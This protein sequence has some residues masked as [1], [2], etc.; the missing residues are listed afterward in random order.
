M[1]DAPEI[2]DVMKEALFAGIVIGHEA[3]IRMLFDAMLG[4]VQPD[5]RDAARA[6]GIGM[7]RDFVAAGLFPGLSPEL[8]AAARQRAMEIVADTLRPDDRG[9]RH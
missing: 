1:T 8:A 2:P 7:C 5:K 3:M 4:F 9:A 6:T